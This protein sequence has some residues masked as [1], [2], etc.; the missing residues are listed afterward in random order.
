MIKIG[1]C[2]IVKDEEKNLERCLSAL[3]KGLFHEIVIEDTGSTDRTIEVAEKYKAKVIREPWKNDFAYHRNHV[4]KHAAADWIL[5]LDA[6][7]MVECPHPHLFIRGL[8]E[9]ENEISSVTVLVKNMRKDGTCFYSAGRRITRKD[10]CVWEGR[11]HEVPTHQSKTVGFHDNLRLIHY[12]YDGDPELMEKKRLRNRA[13]L[14][15][16]FKAHEHKGLRII[17]PKPCPAELYRYIIQNLASGKE[18]LEA[19]KFAKLFYQEHNRVDVNTAYTMYMVNAEG[20]K[21]FSRANSWLKAGMQADPTSLDLA[22]AIYHMGKN[23]GD[24]DTLISGGRLYVKAY[25]R[26]SKEG[27]NARTLNNCALLTYTENHCNEV[28]TNLSTFE[29]T[30]AMECLR[31][32]GQSKKVNK[33]IVNHLYSFFHNLKFKG[34]VSECSTD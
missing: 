20:M 11:I 9:A 24:S 31:M 3:P 22:Y 10:R 18:Y 15:E 29:I 27:L 12:G 25:Q 19:E 2:M 17:R 34:R 30:D 6:D 33:K 23:T 16:M 4:E 8:M 26:I 21:D 28:L 32:L 14:M 1:L 13:I 5:H 7:E